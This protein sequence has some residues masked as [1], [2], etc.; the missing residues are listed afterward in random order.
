VPG[1]RLLSLRQGDRAYCP[2]FQFA[3]AHPYRQHELVAALWQRLDADSDPA[4]ATAWW[5]TRSPWLDA[6]P[7]DL[8]GT[9]RDAEI[10]YAADQLA[11]DNW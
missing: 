9:G 8:L 7:A 2:L 11:N 1:G 3:S 5:L 6:R 4:G 10:G